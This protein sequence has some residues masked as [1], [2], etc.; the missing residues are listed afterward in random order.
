MNKFFCL[1]LLFSFSLIFVLSETSDEYLMTP[2]GYRHAS[3]VHEVLSGSIITKQEAFFHVAEPTG[4]E[5][6]IP[7]CSMPRKIQQQK[8]QSLPASGWQVFTF[9]NGSANLTTF[10]GK[11]NVPDIPSVVSSQLLYLFTGLVNQAWTPPVTGSPFIEEDIIQPV[12]Q[13]GVGPAGGGSYWGLASWY[14]GDTAIHS[15]LIKVNPNDNIYG[16]MQKDPNVI[17]KWD[18]ISQDT[19]TSQSVQITVKNALTLEE[20]WATVTLEVYNVYSCS[21][22][23]TQTVNFNEL[24]VEEFGSTVEDASWQVGIYQ[25]VCKEQVSVVSSSEVDIIW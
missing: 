12:L 17:G 11:W 5:Y 3:C 4:K 8:Q 7:H 13:F 9:F 19:T 20:P 1:L 2:S 6:T 23:P 24:L 16:I 22:Y 18:I 10:N 21:N 15:N 14:V 25:A